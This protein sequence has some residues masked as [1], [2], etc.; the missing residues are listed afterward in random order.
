[1]PAIITHYL[2]S[3]M[4]VPPLIHDMQ[5]ANVYVWGS[6]GP[7]FLFFSPP[8]HM[9][10]RLLSRIG[11]LMHEQD[12]EKNFAFM[13]DCCKKAKGKEKNILLSYFY[14]FLSHYILDST[15]HPYV[16]GLQRYFKTVLPKASNNYLHRQIETTLDV[17][18]L[19]RFRN[20][21][22][23]DFSVISH[24]QR[25]PELNLVC[26]MYQSLFESRFK[27]AFP[28]RAISHAFLSMK[29]V[30]SFFYSP[31][32]FKRRAVTFA[33]RLTQE[34]HPAIFALIHPVEPGKEIDYANE[35]RAL[36]EPGNEALEHTAY[37]LFDIAR[38]KFNTVFPLVEQF[39]REGGGDFSAVTHGINFEGNPTVDSFA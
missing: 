7:D 32:G 18:F 38:K 13:A 14:G 11:S 9:H 39:C 5:C 4:V 1:M 17:L 33:K 35:K 36:H 31:R 30:Y 37:E 8:V 21:T 20:M 22:I 34:S 25:I 6:Q 15:F 27:Q 29:L 23:Q 16:Y 12:M 24:F 10:W 26:E 19:K 3:E 28:I 2:F